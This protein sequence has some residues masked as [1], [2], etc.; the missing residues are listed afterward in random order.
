MWYSGFEWADSDCCMVLDAGSVII[1]KL[2]LMIM[3]AGTEYSARRFIGMIS[4]LLISS[5]ITVGKG[6]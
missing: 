1:V 6:L 5:G 2:L 4:Y 3:S